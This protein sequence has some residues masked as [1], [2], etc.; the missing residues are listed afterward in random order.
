MHSSRASRVGMPLLGSGATWTGSWG[1]TRSLKPMPSK[2]SRPD[3]RA[4]SSP[5]CGPTRTTT[6]GA[7][8]ILRHPSLI[9]L[10]RPVRLFAVGSAAAVDTDALVIGAGPAGASVS[11]RLAQ[12]GWRVVLVEQH[13][14]PRQK[15][16]GE[17]IAA[18]NMT[19]IDELGI[20]LAFSQ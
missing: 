20:G 14:Y 10:P 8:N 7:T 13:E 18:G 4:M 12:A 1:S 19:L 16:C 5:E 9:A 11:I 3:S 15:V 17:C 2:V 6:G